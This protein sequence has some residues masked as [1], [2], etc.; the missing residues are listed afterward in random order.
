MTTAT[1]Q[2][3]D[4]TIESWPC[5]APVHTSVEKHT[6]MWTKSGHPDGVKHRTKDDGP[7][8]VAITRQ[9]YMS[10]RWFVNGD[11][12]NQPGKPCVIQ[13]YVDTVNKSVKRDLFW[14]INFSFDKSFCGLNRLYGNYQEE[15]MVNNKVVSRDEYI[16]FHEMV[17]FKE[18]DQS[19]PTHQ[20]VDGWLDLADT[21]Y[22]EY[23]KLLDQLLPIGPVQLLDGNRF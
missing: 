16:M 14:A 22:K 20:Q 17:Y 2:Q 19:F 6:I 23:E 1:L 12:T 9:N 21:A 4:A 18:F 5:L 7:A 3:L 11:Y 15:W 10:C 8:Y 13:C